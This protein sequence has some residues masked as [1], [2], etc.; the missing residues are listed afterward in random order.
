MNMTDFLHYQRFSAKSLNG[1]FWCE[2]ENILLNK[3]YIQADRQKG[4]NL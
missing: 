1:E 3:K 2:G 4:P